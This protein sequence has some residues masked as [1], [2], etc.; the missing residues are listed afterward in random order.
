V[1]TTTFSSPGNQDRRFIVKKLSLAATVLSLCFL[2]FAQTPSAGRINTQLKAA[3]L[4]AQKSAAQPT[5]HRN[6]SSADCVF[7]FTS[8]T[9]NTFLKYCVTATGNVTVFESPRRHEHIAVGVDGEGYGICGSTSGVAY[10]DYAERGDS[11]NWGLP[12]VVSHNATS[13]TIAR[14][15]S[16][17][18]WT[19]TQ[20]FT[21][22][23]GPSPSARITMTLRNNTAV[24]TTAIL[25]RYADVD[26]SGVSL[27]NL[28]ATL[29]SAFG[30]NS[31][32]AN[33]RFGLVLQTVGNPPADILAGL[34]Q[35]VPD[36][37]DPCNPFLHEAAGPVTG[38]DGSIGMLYGLEIPQGTSKTVTVRYKGF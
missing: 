1:S 36:G 25:L 24:D 30:W 37:P 7:I 28:D 23:A 10:F 31:T 32:V 2:S 9:K 22:V 11:G 12:T 27:N 6:P 35:D 20:T 21:Q 13:V 3:G 15:T 26:A 38:T 14:T 8:G 34:A 4:S 16:D 5:L 33:T 17:G 18:L 29:E 19:L